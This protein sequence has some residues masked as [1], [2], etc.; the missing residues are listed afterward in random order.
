MLAGFTLFFLLFTGY[1]ALR[2]V[3]ETMGVAGGVDRLQWLFTGTFIATLLAL[4]LYGWLAA[5]VPP[6]SRTA[7]GPAAWR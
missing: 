4:P 2:P 3:R 6:A 5:R 1:F 7:A